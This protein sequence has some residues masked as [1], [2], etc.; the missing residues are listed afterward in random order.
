MATRPSAIVVGMSIVHIGVTLDCRDPLQLG[1]FWSEALGLVAESEGDYLLLRGDGRRS[2]LQ[3]FTLQRVPE[4]KVVKN[5]MHFDLVVTEVAVEVARLEQLGA[6]I[7]AREA[8]PTAYEIV[9]MGD[10]EGNE[11]CVIKA[12]PAD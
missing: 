5:R 2:G 4:S 3:G 12:R 11:F 6:T 10:P 7:I 9:V 1:A 8:E